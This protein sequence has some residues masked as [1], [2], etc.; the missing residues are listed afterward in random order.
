MWAH[1][2]VKS[3]AFILCFSDFPFYLHISIL[4]HP[5]LFSKTFLKTHRFRSENSWSKVFSLHCNQR[6]VLLLNLLLGE[7]FQSK[8][9]LIKHWSQN[10]QK[11][12]KK[13]REKWKWTT[14]LEINN[15]KL[16]FLPYGLKTSSPRLLARSPSCPTKCTE[17]WILILMLMLR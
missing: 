1:A 13:T 12:T 17:V 15:R 16:E 9:T 11:D 2:K 10:N 3:E 4:W 8:R 7:Y 6:L 14:K 5:L